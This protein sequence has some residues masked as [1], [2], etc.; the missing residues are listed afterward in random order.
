M[1]SKVLIYKHLH[2]CPPDFLGFS[3]H[4]ITFTFFKT[5]SGEK[6]FACE[7]G[8]STTASDDYRTAFY[9]LANGQWTDVTAKVFPFQFTFADFW[10]GALP[11]KPL[12]RFRTHLELLRYG[13]DVIV[14]ILGENLANLPRFFPKETDA[15]KHEQIFIAGRNF[16]VIIFRWDKQK[17]IFVQKRKK[18]EE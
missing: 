13:T 10:R 12:Q 5:Q 1:C 15:T 2:R 18:K 9:S 7:K 16:Y 3:N 4:Y 14:H 11:P 6:I 8:T 17:G